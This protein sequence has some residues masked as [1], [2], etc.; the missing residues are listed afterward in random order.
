[1]RPWTLSF[2][3]GTDF[4]AAAVERGGRVDLLEVDGERRIPSTVALTP[5]GTLLA[6]HA[7][8]RACLRHPDRAERRPKR[9]VG[10]AP[11]LLGGEPVSAVA[12]VSALLRP[13]V[14][15]AR[16]LSGG[17]DPGRFIATHPAA[18]S[19]SRRGELSEAAERVLP[20]VPVTLL[21]EPLAAA[22]HFAAGS[23][24]AGDT[25]AVI[26]MSGSAATV[27]VVAAHRDGCDIVG[28]A[29]GDPGTGGDAFDQRVYEHFGRRL[30]QVAPEW[31]GRV[32]TDP[33]H[34]WLAA[35]MDLL[36]EARTARE[37]LSDRQQCHRHLAGAGTH[38]RLDRTE[39]HDLIGVDVGRAGR[40]LTET[41]DATGGRP[42][43]VLLA[44][45]V[46]RTPLVEQTLRS[47]YGALVRTTPDP[48]GAVARGAA[49]W[50]R[51]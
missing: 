41:I 21:A 3:L 14:D 6:G 46:S 28:R 44:G 51:R 31:W 8:T 50:A 24:T 38:L 20:G 9:Y 7:A 43:A 5:D 17:T 15:R 4:C 30:R 22:A 10:R 23:P 37:A 49:R 35:A 25:V 2:D 1:M 19:G 27:T 36:T 48:K 40:L 45:G 47:T 42:A 13:F 16:H 26:D 34:R 29:H 32:R 18:W 12:A 11:M 39:L 33:D